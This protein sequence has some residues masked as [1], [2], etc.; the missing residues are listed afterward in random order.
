MSERYWDPQLET[1]PV[2]RRRLLRDHR[3]RWQ[4]RRCWDGSPFYRA[5]LE[6]AGLDPATFGGLADLARVPVLRVEDLPK[7]PDADE[8]DPSWTVAPG[9]W[10]RDS[11]REGPRVARMLTDG[12]II[13]QMDIAARALWAAGG[14]PGHTL[15]LDGIGDGDEVTDLIVGAAA[16]IGMGLSRV[17]ADASVGAGE[18]VRATF[19]EAEQLTAALVWRFVWPPPGEDRE[20]AGCALVMWYVAPTVAYS[21]GESEGVHWADDHLLV[22]IVDPATEQAVDPGEPGALVL[23]D[24]TREGSPLLRYWSGLEATLIEEP[25][26]CGRTSIR[27]TVIRPLALG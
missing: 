25:C 27:S 20:Q 2:E 24:L 17:S 11:A 4:V 22:E 6:S 19:H 16:R 12:D 13:H 8:P 3:L 15:V 5:R 9:D 21:C 23:S 18:R 7:G 14:R 26:A 10:R 1:L